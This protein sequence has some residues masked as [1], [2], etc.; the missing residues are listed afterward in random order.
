MTCVTTILDDG[1]GFP[2]KTVDGLPILSTLKCPPDGLPPKIGVSL[3]S[4]CNVK[5]SYCFTNGYLCYRPLTAQEIVAQVTKVY[6]Y[7]VRNDL[8]WDKSVKLWPGCVC[9]KRPIKISFKQM[10]DPLFNPTNTI[11]AI[12]TL[13]KKHYNFVFVVSTSGPRLQ[14]NDVFFSRLNGFYPCKP[15]IN[16]QFSCH[17]TSNQERRRLLPKTP[18]MTLEEI[19]RYANRDKQGVALNFVMFDGFEYSAEKIA[20]LFDRY[21]TFVKINYIDHNTYTKALGL[22]D[23]PEK[24]VD[25]FV[26]KLSKLGFDW[27]YR[28]RKR[29]KC[30]LIGEKLTWIYEDISD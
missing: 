24:K 2:S 9:P 7:A 15:E 26:S 19:S 3:C 22:K 17:T 12:K 18:I 8:I 27:N 28:S 20:Y 13:Y 4:G 5:C 1:I 29:W 10:G 16:L 11:E 23:M 6:N 25:K 14:S 21:N 30:K